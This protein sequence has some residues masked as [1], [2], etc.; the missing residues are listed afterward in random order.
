MN[1]LFV[2]NHRR[3]WP[4]EIPGASIVSAREYLTDAAYGESQPARVINLCRTERY[5]G[6]GYYVSLL[7]EAQGHHPLP[8]VKT[9][10]DLQADQPDA[11][12]AGLP[13]EH[14]QRAFAGIEGDTASLDT[15][16]GRDP[17]RRNDTLAQR[18][19]A[20]V[21]VP[22][23]RATFV[24]DGGRWRVKAISPLSATDIA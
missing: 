6:R 2:V 19:F 10:G 12:C 7:A 17:L 1:V 14:V 5:Q 23:F 21:P 22:L 20:I 24:R 4:G 3:D 11:L 9:L 18:L 15:Y 13:A 16:F 8:E